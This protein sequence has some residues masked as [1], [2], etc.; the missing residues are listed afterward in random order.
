[1][2]KNAQLTEMDLHFQVDS[3]MFVNLFGFQEVNDRL[4][5]NSMIFL[6]YVRSGY[7]Y[8][9]DTILLNPLVFEQTD[10]FCF[11]GTINLIQ[12]DIFKHFTYLDN[13]IFHLTSLGN[14][15]HK[16][17]IDWMNYLNY[18]TTVKFYSTK[19]NYTYP[20]QDFCIF[21]EFPFSRNISLVLDS[22]ESHISLTYMWLCKK[23]CMT[24]GFA[25]NQTVDLAVFEAKLNFC[26]VIPNLNDYPLYA[27]YYQTN[28]IEMLL[29]DLVPFVFIP[30]ACLIGLF[31]NWKIIHTIKANEKRELKEDFYKYMSANAK[32]NCLYC[33]IL[34]FYP[35]TSCNW[36]QNYLF[37]SS[38][39]TTQFVQ[40]YKIVMIAYFGELIKMCANIC[41]LMMTLNRYLLVGQNHAPWLVTI[42]KLQFKWVIGGSFIFSALINIG[43]GWEY[44]VVENYAII[45]SMYRTF[46]GYLNGY[47]YS[48][49]P[50][51][52]QGTIYFIFSIVYF[53]INFGAFFILNTILEVKIVR[54]L[55]KELKEKRE[56]LV[57]M[58]CAKSFVSACSV[59]AKNKSETAPIQKKREE[60]DE[61]KERKVIKMVLI[62]GFFNFVLRAPDMLFWMENQ[63]IYAAVFINFSFWAVNSGDRLIA[64]GLLNVLA[65]IGYLTYILTFSSNFFV[66]YNFNKNFYEVVT[67]FGT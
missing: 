33:L 64:P 51:A 4:S 18:G 19:I 39:F 63:D 65:D 31:F 25:F 13:V 48:N 15:F 53:V 5:I 38:I 56:R 3:F 54:R 17:S 49:Y 59:V 12:T 29:M 16:I 24:S 47:S 58:N 35:M 41:Y 21:S 44:Q 43:H 55:Q 57:K 36:R 60:E 6:F 42:A 11:Y 2:F 67:F 46:D 14:F 23:G 62:N 66:F 50:L 45:H 10:G 22:P 61:E 37:C 7:N 40:Y 27:D 32:F 28:L 26:N 20:N 52:N 1:V 30:C 9:L 8:K 34:V